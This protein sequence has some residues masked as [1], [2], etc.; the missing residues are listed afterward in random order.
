MA[1]PVD[2]QRVVEAIKETHGEVDQVGA[3][4]KR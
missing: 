4:K 2:P 3:D 1:E